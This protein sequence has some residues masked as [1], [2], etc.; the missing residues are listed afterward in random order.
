[1]FF[2]LLIFFMKHRNFTLMLDDIFVPCS[3]F[4]HFYSQILTWYSGKD[5]LSTTFFFKY[6]TKT[7]QRIQRSPLII[8]TVINI[9]SIHES[10]LKIKF[11]KNI[12]IQSISYKMHNNKNIW[13]YGRFSGKA[14]VKSDLSELA[15][16]R[17]STLAQNFVQILL[18]L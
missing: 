8:N 11:K 13:T 4:R 15:S 9:L 5:R 16:G 12:N 6:S 10:N 2:Y 18:K 7:F 1:M 3:L 14:C 17:N